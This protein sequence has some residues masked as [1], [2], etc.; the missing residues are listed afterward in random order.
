MAH[1]P[2]STGSYHHDMD[3]AE[4]ERTYLGFL[5]LVKWGIIVN[6]VILVGMAVF[7]L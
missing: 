4:H 7:L 5:T 2:Q 6:V 3:G 1:A